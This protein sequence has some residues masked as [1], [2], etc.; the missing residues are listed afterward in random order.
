VL[1]VEDVECVS[2]LWVTVFDVVYVLLIAERE[3]TAG[4]TD[5]FLI[6]S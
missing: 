4:L 3:A 5:I 6:A 2:R 1:I